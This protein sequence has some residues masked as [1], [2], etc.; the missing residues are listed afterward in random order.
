[1]DVR[2]L[3]IPDHNTEKYLPHCYV[4]LDLYCRDGFRKQSGHHFLTVALDELHMMLLQVTRNTFAK[5]LPLVEKAL[6]RCH[7]YAFDLEM[8]GLHVVD[9][10]EDYLDDIQERY[11]VVR[12]GRM[13]VHQ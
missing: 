7:F 3:V 6:D 1:M 11:E 5:A 2:T 12:D 8:T 9:K 13:H 4:F 10:R